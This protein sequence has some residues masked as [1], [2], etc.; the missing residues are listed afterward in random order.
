VDDMVFTRLRL[1]HA[2]VPLGPA[3]SFNKDTAARQGQGRSGP[4]RYRIG[5]SH[6]LTR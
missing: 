2:S 1:F 4:G 3:L 6:P 5:S